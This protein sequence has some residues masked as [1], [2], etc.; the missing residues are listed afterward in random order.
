M[1]ETEEE[2]TLEELVCICDDLVNVAKYEKEQRKQRNVLIASLYK[3]GKYNIKE[4]SDLTMIA[5]IN[6]RK[7]LI[8]E[9]L[10]CV[11]Q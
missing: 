8:N 2:N 11:D 4:L 6:I 3:T 10:I 9:G 7:V 5:R 1:T